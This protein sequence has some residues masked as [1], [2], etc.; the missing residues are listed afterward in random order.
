MTDVPPTL[1]V[2]RFTLVT[3]VIPAILTLAALVVQLFALPHVPATIAVHWGAS[4]QADGFGPAWTQIVLSVVV[5]F[6]LPLLF[7][8]ICLPGLRRGD[9]GPTYRLMGTIASAMSALMAV[10][11]AW[12]IVAQRGLEDAKDAPSV[13]PGMAWAF[14]IAIVVGIVA[15]FLQPKAAPRNV[16]SVPASGITLVDGEQAVWFGTASMGRGATLV[17]SGACVVLAGAALVVWFA[18]APAGIGILIGVVALVVVAL[19]LMTS[20]FH[21]RVDASGLAVTSFVGFPRFHVALSDI[22]SVDV[23]D[24][25]PMGEFGGYGIRTTVGAFGVVLRRGSAITVTRA[26]G[27]RFVVTVDDAARG[28]A[29]LQALAQRA[30]AEKS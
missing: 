2:R 16:T 23:S 25:S 15:W 13:L 8:L 18:G 26:S 21:V 14:G 30:A 4:G 3:L 17:I 12:T 1:A 5:G 10:L 11:F 9:N 28:G 22:R 27:R 24:V 6:G 7:A 20:A 29:L 19:A